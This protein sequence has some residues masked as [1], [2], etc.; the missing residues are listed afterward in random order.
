MCRSVLHTIIVTMTRLIA[1]QQCEDAKC[2]R[3]DVV[4]GILLRKHFLNSDVRINDVISRY[5]S[6]PLLK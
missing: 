6:L 1:L 2:F 5:K 3:I 4:S